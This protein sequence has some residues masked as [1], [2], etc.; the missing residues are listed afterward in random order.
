[1]TP[2]EKRAVRDAHDLTR[3]EVKALRAIKK[4][5]QEGIE[6]ILQADDMACDA[7]KILKDVLDS[8]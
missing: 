3:R 7:R 2:I 8:Q 6:L 4:V 5:G 1:M